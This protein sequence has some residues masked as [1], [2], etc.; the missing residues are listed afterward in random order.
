MNEQDKLKEYEFKL[1][2]QLEDGWKL[3][4]FYVSPV[5]VGL[6]L[7][8][9]D[10]CCRLAREP[11][12]D[13]LF[14]I[15][16][17]AWQ[18]D[19]L[20]PLVVCLGEHGAD[21]PN[22]KSW[23]RQQES[24]RANFLL[25]PVQENNR[26]TELLKALLVPD[27]SDITSF[28]PPKALTLHQFWDQLEQSN[29]LDP[30]L[31][32]ILSGW[33]NIEEPIG[34]TPKTTWLFWQKAWDEMLYRWDR[35]KVFDGASGQKTASDERSEKIPLK[36]P[37]KIY[38][39][40]KAASIENFKGISRLEKIDLDADIIL[41]TGANGNG[42]SSFVEAL[43]LALTGHHPSWAS[44]KKVDH[45][46]FYG[47]ET[48][49]ITLD[50]VPSGVS[51][52]NQQPLETIKVEGN[53]D[54][55]SFTRIPALNVLRGEAAETGAEAGNRIFI[56]ADE[57]LNFRMT[58]Y[59]PDFVRLLFDEAIEEERKKQGQD[60]ETGEDDES[61][62]LKLNDKTNLLRQFFPALSPSIEALC[63]VVER[64]LGE[65]GNVRDSLARDIKDL[66]GKA[67]HRQQWQDLVQ[68]VEERIRKLPHPPARKYE[69]DSR[70]RSKTEIAVPETV[71]L[72]KTERSSLGNLFSGKIESWKKLD[73]FM[74]THGKSYGQE[75]TVQEREDLEKEIRDLRMRVEDLQEQIELAESGV[76][77]S[78]EKLR[79]VLFLLSDSKEREQFF[80][81]LGHGILAQES[82]EG[83]PG[84]PD[85][86]RECKLVDPDKAGIFAK[87]LETLLEQRGGRLD[88]LKEQK[89]KAER[90]LD[91][92]QKRLR[93]LDDAV[94]M[95]REF[96]ELVQFLRQED[97][98]NLLE[99][100][101]KFEADAQNYE[102]IKT[103]HDVLEKR[104][105]YLEQLS[106][107][108]KDHRK[109]ILQDTDS[110][111]TGSSF[112]EVF[113]KTINNV[114]RRFALA[115][116]IEEIILDS[117]FRITAKDE[118]NKGETGKNS[119][120]TLECFSA[121]QKAQLATAW[122]VAS[123]EVI[124]GAGKEDLYFPHRILI[125]DDPS[126][127]FDTTNL[128]SQAILWRQL[129]YNPDPAHRYQVFI[130]S[131]HE[132]FSSRLLDLLCPPEG[133]GYAMKLLRFTNWTQDDGAAIEQFDV[134][135]AAKD[136][137]KAGENFSYGLECFRDLVCTR[138]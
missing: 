137:Q 120:R 58:T 22:I 55:R 35:F 122:L 75:E 115:D 123:R 127:T 67:S 86:V 14:T 132:E 38:T 100:M 53:K 81:M 19:L 5:G 51:D 12:F 68:Q 28:I 3:E 15:R 96:E 73:E 50:M 10:D 11:L 16:E 34:Q 111:D 54:G 8:R 49:H 24:H 107:I 90:G 27:P 6:Y 37:D 1:S 52:G 117:E 129:A 97:S 32:D 95:P 113:E 60:G 103:E 9:N 25:L 31:I 33:K 69:I 41:V 85:L 114:L 47:Q 59:L 42:K 118:K 40:I 112:R 119:R 138:H 105:A 108:I 133:E 121:G 63:R 134:Q 83:I 56:P 2:A 20:M 77:E 74:E 62:C 109:K 43:S 84:Q 88:E 72:L 93:S 130:V 17:I 128:L 70:W 46:F 125:M 126:T 80:E 98:K 76:S 57:E 36:P 116:G 26:S 48:F 94:K 66:E 92:K 45:F 44:G 82:K 91:E 136:L 71:E 106:Q 18:A 13:L 61:T 102:K 87:M 39:R 101:A 29:R 110:K 30:A 124:M 21:L 65:Y 7:K 99:E 23:R 4:K 135:V 131:H 79:D 64:R 78:I 89:E 104:K